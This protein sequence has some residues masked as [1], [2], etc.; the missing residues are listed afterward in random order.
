[1]I[2][3]PDV[4]PGAEWLKITLLSFCLLKTRINTHSFDGLNSKIAL[5]IISFHY[6]GFASAGDLLAQIIGVFI[7]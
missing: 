4:I 5:P 6:L 3:F 1:M 2:K 7:C